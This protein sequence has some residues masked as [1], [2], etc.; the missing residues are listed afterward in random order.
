MIQKNWQELIKPQKLNVLKGD[1]SLVGPRPH[2]PS[3][4]AGEKLRQGGKIAFR[5]P[6]LRVLASA[7]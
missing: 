7:R 3:T 4:R 5:F 6:A 1:L 2:A